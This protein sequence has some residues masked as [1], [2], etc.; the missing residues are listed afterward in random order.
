MTPFR[1]HVQH[2]PLINLMG[3][4]KFLKEI[5]SE[6]WDHFWPLRKTFGF[7]AKVYPLPEEG[8]RSFV[9]AICVIPGPSDTPTSPS[10]RSA[11]RPTNGRPARHRLPCTRRRGSLERGGGHRGGRPL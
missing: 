5:F 8:H 9:V 2:I 1:Q 10:P 4:M 11:W 3:L 6:I 7:G